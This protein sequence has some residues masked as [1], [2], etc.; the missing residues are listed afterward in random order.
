MRKVIIS[1]TATLV[2]VA[3]SNLFN[4][5]VLAQ[6]WHDSLKTARNAKYLSDKEKA[7]IYEINKVRTDPKRY[8]KLLKN[9]LKSYKGMHLIREGRDPFITIEGP[10]GLKDCMSYLSKLK[11][12][13]VLHP[14]E[15]LFKAAELHA[16]DLSASGGTGHKGSDGSSTLDRIKKFAPDGYTAY[17][18]GICIRE[19]EVFYIV[20]KLLIDD[21]IPSKINLKNMTSENYNKCGVSLKSHPEYDHVCVV[22]YAQ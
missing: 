14:D 21:G 9:E 20:L 11:P 3:V 19:K 13:C 12:M 4:S 15:N 5:N 10:N 22:I 6:E 16:N 17:N 18:E 1:F 7:I 8:A 2:I